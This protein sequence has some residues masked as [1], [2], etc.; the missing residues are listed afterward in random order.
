MATD[1]YQLALNLGCKTDQARKIRDI[2]GKDTTDWQTVW[3]QRL[4]DPDWL[5][6]HAG[7]VA[8]YLD[9]AAMR[10]LVKQ[11][12]ER[13]DPFHPDNL[14]IDAWLAMGRAGCESWTEDIATGEIADRHTIRG[15]R[16]GAAPQN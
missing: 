3:T 1:P 15:T 5:T 9:V 12:K 8:H 10:R 4:T 2:L 11:R 6:N 13:E 16:Q 7:S 14:R